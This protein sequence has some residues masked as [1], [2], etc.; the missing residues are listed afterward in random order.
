MDDESEEQSNAVHLA[1]SCSLDRDGFF[2]RA[3]SSCGRE[4]K[5]EAAPTDLQWALADQCRRHGLDVGETHGGPEATSSLHCPYCGHTD[6]SVEMYTADTVDYMKRVVYRECVLPL[7]SNIFGGFEDSFGSRRRSS[8]PIAISMSFNHERDPL[9]PR[10]SHGPE[11]PDQK[12]V[13][14]LCCGERAKI[15]EAWH[16]V[17][18]CIYCGTPVALSR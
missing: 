7:L 6:R 1:V 12:I 5:T 8:G 3:C 2:R 9:P 4:F 15:D 17:E 11:A 14:F 13:E 18:R 16:G 10:P